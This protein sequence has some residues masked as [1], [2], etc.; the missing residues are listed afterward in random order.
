MVKWLL[1]GVG[2]LVAIVGVSVFLLIA[3]LDDLV[4]AFVEQGGSQAAKV[5]VRLE[6]AEIRLGDASATLNGLTVANPEGFE[7]G[8]AFVLG[9][10]GVVIDAESLAYDPIVIKEVVVQA[11]RVTYE[12]GPGGSNID[13]IRKNVEQTSAAAV[14]G[15]SDAAGESPRIVIEHLYLRQAAV[16]VSATSIGGKS[17]SATLPEIHLTDI[18]RDENGA[19]PA[20]VAAE[21]MTALTGRVNGFVSGLDLSGVLQGVENLPASLEGLTGAA[22]GRAGDAVKGADD[23][24]KKLFGN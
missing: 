17:M 9:S 22:A 10:I 4:K 7:S 23:P 8:N 11:P 2:G 24:V 13:A 3:G 16:D 1:I 19:T 18:G 15:S 12:I 6:K 14:G 5:D 21:V 20:E